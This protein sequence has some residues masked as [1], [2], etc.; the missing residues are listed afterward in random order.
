[1]SYLEHGQFHAGKILNLTTLELLSELAG[2]VAKQS[3]SISFQDK[4]KGLITSESK[5]TAMAVHIAL[6]AQMELITL[7]IAEHESSMQQLRDREHDSQGLG[8]T[9]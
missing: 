3:I 7:L 5:D 2:S 1:M 6:Q 4:E 8:Q 9:Q